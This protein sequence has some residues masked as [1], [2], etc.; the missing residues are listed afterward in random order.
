MSVDS[1]LKSLFDKSVIQWYKVV[2][3]LF[4]GLCIRQLKSL[5]IGCF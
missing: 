5:W 4:T 1:N 2:E 3:I